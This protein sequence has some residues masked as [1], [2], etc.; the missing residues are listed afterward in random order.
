MPEQKLK[1]SLTLP[2]LTLYGLGNILGAGIYVLVGKVAG[3]SGSST[4]LAFLIA[5][6]IA[7]FTA[8]SYMELSS[9][10]P[11]SA[12]ASIYLYKA[13][14][15]RILALIVGFALIFG[16]ITSAA[17]LSKGFSGYLDSIFPI[18]ETVASILLILLLGLIAAKGIGA[19][20]KL[21]AL[22]TLVEVAGLLIIIWAG[23]SHLTLGG[24]TSSF[25]IDPAIG[26]NGVLFG[27]FLAFYAFIGFE[28]MVNVSEEVKKP[29]TT[30]PLAILLS[31]GLAT[32]L[33]VL[34][35]MVSLSSVGAELL[36]QSNAPLNLVFDRVSHIDPFYI[37]LIG[38]AAT[39]NGI[40]VQIIMGSR[41][42]YGL[43]SQGWMHKRF[44]RVHKSYGTPVFSTA[45]VTGAIILG[46]ILFGL[47][48][49]AEI[50]S[51]LILSAFTLVNVGL[52]ILKHR[53]K[54]E[55]VVVKV[56]IIVPVLGSISC[57]GIMAFQLFG[58]I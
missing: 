56:P 34:V 31:L 47:V 38:I 46:T 50:T 39:V 43:S 58:K 54:S 12:S 40:L 29:R 26:I 53:D 25:H 52:V 28:D 24:L 21:A 5:M 49:L 6:L 37:S 14:K 42:F 16:G 15:S 3:Y 7:S 55:N 48:S 10:Y 2:L 35:V 45:V 1:R 9:R 4:I 11:V 8:L 23:H 22:F 33:Y 18:N 36:S 32:V 57:V 51:L 13:F 41:I 20:A 44:S 19:S 27:A 30:M 17:A